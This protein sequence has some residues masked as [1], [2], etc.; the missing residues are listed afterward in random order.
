M[1]LE[2]LF[3]NFMIFSFAGWVWETIVC[4]LWE[5]GHF[6]NRGSL[7]GPY[8]PVYGGGAT[9]GVLLG[10]YINEPV[11]LFFYS[12]FLCICAEY[13]CGAILE[14]LFKMKLWDYSGMAFQI[15]GRV[16]LLG[17]LFFGTA[18]VVIN[19]FVEPAILVKF[20]SMNPETLQ[21]IACSLAILLAMDTILSALAFQRVNKHL[22]RFYICWHAALNRE[23]RTL[24]YAIQ[25]RCPDW[26]VEDLSS[27]QTAIL[28]K[29]RMLCQKQ[30][31]YK[32][33]LLENIQ[34]FRKS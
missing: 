7:L 13:L 9:A 28:E 4:S 5:S 1:T 34:R 30:E 2:Y 26:F 3:L 27:M 16:C 10:L 23:F 11:K 33:N 25:K 14:N 17:F 8:C 24:S 29:N 15:K 12:A 6:L 21:W 19:K 31:E 20:D 18:C 32:Q 22:Y